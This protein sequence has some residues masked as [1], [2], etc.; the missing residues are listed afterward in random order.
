MTSATTGFVVWA[1]DRLFFHGGMPPEV[2]GFLQVTIPSLMGFAGAEFIYWRQK[3]RQ[4]A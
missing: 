3:H 2:Y 4:R 1:V